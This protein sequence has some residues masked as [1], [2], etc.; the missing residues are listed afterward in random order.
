MSNAAACL[1]IAVGIVQM[2]PNNSALAISGTWSQPASGG[3]W[4]NS[5]NWVSGN[6]ADG[7]NFTA[8]FST[9]NLTADNTANLNTARTLG[10]LIFRRHHALQ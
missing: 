5:A 3:L 7:S 8:D 10:N 4:S 2:L 1:A 6:I 9:L